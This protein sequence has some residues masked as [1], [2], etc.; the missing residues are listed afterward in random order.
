MNNNNF[1][2]FWDVMFIIFVVPKSIAILGVTYEIM[3]SFAEAMAHHKGQPFSERR[4]K[5][6]ALG[7]TLVIASLLT[8]VGI[9]GGV[10]LALLGLML[11]SLLIPAVIVVR[12]MMGIQKKEKYLSFSFFMYML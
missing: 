10:E 12:M 1:F 6:K 2:S 8:A 4:W 9:L 3:E 5:K 11:T 7:T